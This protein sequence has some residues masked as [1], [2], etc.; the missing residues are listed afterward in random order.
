MSTAEM[1]ERIAEASPPFKARRSR[2]L[3]HDRSHHAHDP[4]GFEPQCVN[5]ASLNI[6]VR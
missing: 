5:L 4:N 3:A 6:V 2:L 1:T